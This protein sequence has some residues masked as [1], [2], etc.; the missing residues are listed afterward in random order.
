MDTTAA[1]AHLAQIPT[2]YQLTLGILVF[3]NAMELVLILHFTMKKPQLILVSS[4]APA[5]P[6]KLLEITIPEHVS[7]SVPT[8]PMLMLISSDV[9]PTVQPPL[10]SQDNFFSEI[11]HTGDVF[12]TVQ[13]RHLTEML[14]I[15]FAIAR[16]QTQQIQLAIQQ[17]TLQL[18]VFTNDVFQS[19]HIT[20]L[21]N[22]LDIKLS[23]FPCVLMELGAIQ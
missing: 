9:G 21:F 14:M 20:Q 17:I 3:V 22:S 1:I 10:S 4:S 16:V 13:P 11:K 7:L 19:A 2:E 5:F 23:A 15:E 12:L 18:M 6:L 8:I